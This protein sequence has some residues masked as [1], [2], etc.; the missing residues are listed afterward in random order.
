MRIKSITL[1][2]IRLFGQEAQTLSFDE[3]KPVTVILGNNG[4]GKSTILDAASIML[5]TFTGS[6]PGNA[7][8][9]FN[10]WDVHIQHSDVIA[11]HLVYKANISAEKEYEISRYRKGFGKAPASNLK[12]FKEYA[13]TLQKQIV[14]GSKAIELPVLAYYGTNRAYLQTPA[15]RTYSKKLYRR[16]DCYNSSLD[17]STEFRRF[18]SWFDN[19][20]D[21]ERREKEERKDFDYRDPVLESVRKA[22]RDL[23]K[24]RYANPRIDIHPLRFDLDQLDNQGQVDKTLRLEQFSDGYKIIIAMVADIASRMA[25]GNPDMDEPL[26]TSGIVLIDEVDLHLHPK[27]QRTIL[28]DLHR[29]FPNVQFIVTTHSPIILL[30]AADIAQIVLLDGSH[31]IDD[32]NL[33]ISRYD[34][35]Q[36]LL[37]QLF[38]L[39]SVY[40]PKY[41]EMF[42]RHEDLLL[43]YHTLTKEEQE[44]LSKLDKQMRDFSYSQSLDDIKINDLVKKMAKKLNI[45]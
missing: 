6:F 32:T 34:V 9:N 42:K 5:S 40:S 15:R 10:D 39:E 28:K 38:G 21:E 45:E 24:G 25:E 26:M 14:E 13:E 7:E 43:R 12:A 27:W 35:S 41:D 22:I 31:I 30:G 16:W 3:N 8:K 33:D 23:L 44:E 17:S 29:V 11:N 18:F 1:Q 37:T 19:K 4:C 20:E 2:N 36:I